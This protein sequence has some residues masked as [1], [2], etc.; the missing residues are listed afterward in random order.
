MIFFLIGYI[1]IIIKTV[2]EYALYAFVLG[3]LTTANMKNPSQ[4]KQRSKMLSDELKRSE[5]RGRAE[6]EYMRR[7]SRNHANR[8]RDAYRR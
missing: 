7:A 5:E 6:S 3:M 2:L 4:S 1:C 8:I